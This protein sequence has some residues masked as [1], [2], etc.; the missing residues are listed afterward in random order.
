MTRSARNVLILGCGVLA[1]VAVAAFLHF[2]R[3][4]AYSPMNACVNN[5]QRIKMAK[6]QWALEHTRT[7]SDVP[8][9]A[10]LRPYFP[11]DF[12]D[13]KDWSNG[14]PICPSGGTYTIGRVG[15][16]PTC[17]IRYHTLDPA[18]MP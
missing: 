10:D 5:L 8:T 7:T 1:C 9:W 6:E 18:Q 3:A 11:K 15:Q 2:A 16:L 13:G 14:L 4:S 12:P 17:T